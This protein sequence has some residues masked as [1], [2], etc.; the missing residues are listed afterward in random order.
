MIISSCCT[1][2]GVPKVSLQS[3]HPARRI[4]RLLPGKNSRET[5]DLLHAFNSLLPLAGL[6]MAVDVAR[7]VRSIV[8]RIRKQLSEKISSI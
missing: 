1:A 2:S 3:Q 6:Q 5:A 4:S 7:L 8:E